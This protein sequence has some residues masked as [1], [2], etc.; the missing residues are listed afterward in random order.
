MRGGV[1]HQP[2]G[3]AAYSSCG[4][5]LQPP[6][7]YS[8]QRANLLQRLTAASTFTFSVSVQ[9]TPCVSFSVSFSSAFSERLAPTSASEERA[10]GGNFCSGSSP[11]HSGSFLFASTLQQQQH[12]GDIGFG[13]CKA[14]AAAARRKHWK[15]Q[16]QH[17]LAD[18]F[19][20]HGVVLSATCPA[21][22]AQAA[23]LSGSLQ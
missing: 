3:G 10:P 7:N 21:E 8:F 6:S 12:C 1:L 5:R 9:R 13:V 14:A 22:A 2:T 20:Q 16:Q 15:Q 19:Q 4:M 11:Q 17:A 23:A 18:S